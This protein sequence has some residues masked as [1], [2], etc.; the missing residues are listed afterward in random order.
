MTKSIPWLKTW[1]LPV[2][3]DIEDPADQILK[4][5][6]LCW[7]CEDLENHTALFPQAQSDNDKTLPGIPKHEYLKSD[8]LVIIGTKVLS[9]LTAYKEQQNWSLFG[10]C[11]WLQF[12]EGGSIGTRLGELKDLEL[13]NLTVHDARAGR[14]SEA[15]GHE[16]WTQ[17]T[18]L[19]LV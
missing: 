6:R 8:S 17:R 4:C 2:N 10:I 5:Y 7:P 18:C 14:N 3:N 9:S 13:S 16:E 15:E 11:N 1:I 12:P 19:S